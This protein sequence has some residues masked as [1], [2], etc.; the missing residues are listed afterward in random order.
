MIL[1]VRFLCG[2]SLGMLLAAPF[3]AHAEALAPLP[4]GFTLTQALDE[5]LQKSPRAAAANAA[6]DAAKGGLE[7]ADTM[8]NPELGLEGENI[9]GNSRYSGF[10]SAE[11]TY[12]LSQ[13][14]EVGGKRGAR[15]KAA[16]HD[17]ALA[18]LTA[19]STRLDIIRDVKQAF[20]ASVAAQ[21]SLNLAKDAVGIAEQEMKSVSRRVAEAASPLIQRS[22][23]EV[24]LATA[25]FN[26]EE[27]T[28]ASTLAQMQLATVLGRD[29][30]VTQP[31]DA[32]YFFA[33]S[34]PKPLDAKRLERTP[35]MLRLREG[36][37]KAAALLGIAK[38]QAVPDPT[39]SL[40]VRELR[41]TSD[42]AFVLGLSIP[43][44][45][46]NSNA[47]GIAK[48]RAEMVETASNQHTERLNLLQRANAAQSAMRTAYVKATSFHDT[49]LP[50]AEKAFSLARQGYN[51]GKFQYLEV[52]DAQ[53]TLFD[54]R[55]QYVGA[56]RDY[57][58]RAADLERLLTPHDAKGDSHEV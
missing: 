38:A 40:G 27:A 33:V 7:Q 1:F 28:Q 17:V 31:L 46:F 16:S 50:A 45:V 53:R 36:E 10:N 42:R 29:A 39:V 52:L 21:E 49:V 44:P 55:A 11:I 12:G 23:A 47:G 26:L 8:P 43:I 18:A 20:A 6:H 58:M 3:G 35:D 57:H 25:Q 22:K 14:I 9:G 41:E 2:A 24:S 37:D 13:Q 30:P 48:A 4:S 15:T 54:A 56:L 32:S 19:A 5:A 34:A 51:A